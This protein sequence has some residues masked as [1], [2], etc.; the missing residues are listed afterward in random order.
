MSKQLS[1]I[2][3][4]KSYPDGT[5]EE[6]FQFH[7]VGTTN[8]GTAVDQVFLS[9]TPSVTLT[10]DQLPPGTYQYEVTKNGETSIESDPF[11]VTVASG[12]S[13][14]VPDATQK[15]PVPTDV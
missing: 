11:T 2:T 3:I 1:V 12:V 15:A 9:P 13:F 5:V 7:V 14:S 4:T 10:P 8:A 6:Q